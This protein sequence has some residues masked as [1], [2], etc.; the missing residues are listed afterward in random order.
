MNLE[1]MVIAG[2]ALACSVLGWFARILYQATQDL[3][4]DL[5]ELEVQIT[6][7]YVRYDRLQDAMKPIMDALHEIKETLKTK[8]DK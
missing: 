1:Q 7:D 2:T 3:K 8:V 4:Q 6:R 5:S